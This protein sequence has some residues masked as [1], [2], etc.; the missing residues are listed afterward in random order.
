MFREGI[1]RVVVDPTINYRFPKV[2]GCESKFWF[3]VF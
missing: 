1:I 3:V 2:R